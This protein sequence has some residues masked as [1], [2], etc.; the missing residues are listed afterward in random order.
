MIVVIPNIRVALDK[1]SAPYVYSKGNCRAL[2][3]S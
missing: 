3:E 1:E 2:V